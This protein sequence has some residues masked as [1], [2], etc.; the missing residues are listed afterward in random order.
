MLEEIKTNKIEGIDAEVMGKVNEMLEEAANNPN[1]VAEKQ[2]E[3]KKGGKK[4][5]KK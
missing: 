2:Q 4:A 3:L 5:G 1:L